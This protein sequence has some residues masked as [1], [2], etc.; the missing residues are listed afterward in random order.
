MKLNHTL[1]CV[2]GMCLALAPQIATAQTMSGQ[3]TSRGPR[4]HVETGDLAGMRQGAAEAFLGIPYAAPP[5]DDNR[6]KAPLP[7]KAWQGV[8]PAT[9]FGASCWQ[10]VNKA[11][12]GPWTHEYV[13][14]DAVSEDCLFVNVWRPA[15]T[16]AAQHLP[17]MVWIHGG[18]FSSGSGSVPIYDGRHLAEK[19]ILVVTINYRV[20]LFGFLAHPD[21][22]AEGKAAGTPPANFGIQDQIAALAWIRR[23]IAS[24]GG[25]PDRVTIAG[26]S[27]GSM[28][29]H[30]LTV[31]PMAR[32][33]FRGAIAESGISLP[34]NDDNV[35]AKA[36]RGGLALSAANGGLSIAD[37]RKIAADKLRPGAGSGPF[38]S[39]V[40]DGSVLTSSVVQSL[41]SGA[42]HDVPM[43]V[44]QNSDEVVSMSAP[45]QAATAEEYD[46]FFRDHFGDMAEE[47]RS[48]FPAHDDATRGAALRR[49][50][51]SNGMA[52]IWQ[53]A[54]VRSRATSPTFVYLF[55]HPEPGPLSAQ[56]KAFHSSEIPYVFETL[57]T[58]P[59]RKFTQ[60]DRRISQGMSDAWVN[61][62][63]FGSPDGKGATWR[64]YSTKTGAVLKIGATS[65]MDEPLDASLL[66]T[67]A[68]FFAKGGTVSLF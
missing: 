5:V 57:D 48:H 21:L 16:R 26:Q 23:N 32:G 3:T 29:V 17:V 64:P 4:I 1:S 43:I 60:V 27:A 40:I 58:A 39:P 51:M 12:F 36:E 41:R 66:A 37:L 8:R 49:A 24:F 55:T 45:S 10:P 35:L 61:F 42:F 18:G 2:L 28:A 30:I 25:D 53:W 56:W 46:R 54:Q 7:A 68:R 62:V 15:G 67:Y 14:Q 22:T 50:H 11:G 33:L 47:F 31:S 20:G 19:G 44:G 6:W 9:A 52:A 65:S 59:E 34:Q 38:Y 13:V 63:K